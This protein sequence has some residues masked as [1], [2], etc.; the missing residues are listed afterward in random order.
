MPKTSRASLLSFGVLLLSTGAVTAYA[1]SPVPTNLPGV[2]TIL[3]VPRSFDPLTASADQLDSAGFPPRPNPLKA[4]HAFESWKRAVTSGA[5]RIM[6]ILRQTDI[7]HGP[8]L[9]SIK[10]GTSLNWSGYAVLNTSVR[11]Y[12]NS[13]FFYLI[14]DYVEPLAQQAFGACTGGWDYSATWVG[15]DGYSSPDVLQA[16]SEA[17][18]YCSRGGGV[19]ASYSFWYEWYPNG[20]VQI[21]NMPLAAGNDAFVHVWSTNSRTGH[22][23]IVNYSNSQSVTLTFSAPSGTVLIGNSAEWVV[24]R[25]SVGDRLAT[26]TNY[27]QDFF[28]DTYAYDFNGHQSAP[29]AAYAGSTSIPL[30][31]LDNSG[32]GIS[33][34]ALLGTSGIYFYDALSARVA[35]DP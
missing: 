2:T 16:G 4:P 23:Y 12:G 33:H 20:E 1:A 34:P 19:L 31:M 8:N 32:A 26:L 24:E 25:P 29:G 28:E 27:I 9:A 15:I 11:S 6:P 35:G 5:S 22:A 17:D 10:N 7:K 13:S 3:S 18:A 21:T 14:G 30:T